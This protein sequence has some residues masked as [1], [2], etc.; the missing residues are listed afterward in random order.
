MHIL[1]AYLTSLRIAFTLVG[2]IVGAGFATGKEIFQ[3]FSFFNG[4]GTIGVLLAGLIYMWTSTKM[5]VIAHTIQARSFNE[6][7]LY[8]FG[9]FFGRILSVTTLLMMIGVTAVML[10]GAGALFHEQ[11]G[12]SPLIGSLLILLI[13]YLFLR[14]GING[15]LMVNSLVIPFMVTC[16]LS[17]AF[18]RGSSLRLSEFLPTTWLPF[19]Y[20]WLLS[21]CY[22]VSFNL[23]TTQAVLVPLGN[24]IRDRQIIKRGGILGG[25]LFCLCLLAGHAALL[26]L[27]QARFFDIPMVVL[28]EQ[29]NSLLYWVVFALIGGEILTTYVGNI[30]GMTRH[31]YGRIKWRET[32]IIIGLLLV[33]FI[34][35]LFDYGTL[36]E[37]LYPF[38]GQIGIVFTIMLLVKKTNKPF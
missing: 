25:L 8:L 35:S 32:Y 23:V 27:K 5:M 26:T 37:S 16:V 11:L 29:I 12:W 10:S 38:F 6:F 15:V 24:E 28:A 7:N 31:L 30:Y 13:C 9:N 20:H 17:M 14:K 3:F 19:S 18:I 4:W 1:K 36:I 34:I 2:T 33:T 22:Y 21:A